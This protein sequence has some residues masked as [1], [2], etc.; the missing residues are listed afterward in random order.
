VPKRERTRID[1]S[2]MRKNVNGKDRFE[3]GSES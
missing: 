1:G 2:R 3:D